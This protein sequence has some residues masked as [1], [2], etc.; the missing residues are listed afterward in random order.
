M[1]R[2]KLIQ[3]RE[4]VAHEHGALFDVLAARRGRISG[5]SSVVLHSPGLAGPWNDVSEFLHG[6]SIVEPEAAELAV[7]V[8]ARHFDCAYVWAAHLPS[9][10]RVGVSE[11]TLTAVAQDGGIDGLPPGEAATVRFV[12]QLL[13]DRRIEQSAFDALLSAHDPR[14]LVE[15]V[16]WIGRYAALSLVIDAFEVTPAADAEV[17]PPITGKTDAAKGAVRPPLPAPRIP[18]LTVREQVAEA[19]RRVFDA[20]AEGRG[21]VRGPF[22]LLL[23]SA[24]LCRIVL[25]LS[26]YFREDNFVPAA[27]RELAIT[28]TAR[29]RDCPYVW[30]AHAPAARREGIDDAVVAAVRDR[31]PVDAASPGEQD[32]VE[33]VRQLLRTHRV[34]QALF[35][36]MMAAHSLPGLVELTAVVGHYVS[37]TTLLNAF[38]VAPAEGAE[39]LP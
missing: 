9:A 1:A 8:T 10:R 34:D 5:P 21:T 24:D 30:A 36:R 6:R 20:V 7:C 32:V 23:H 12:R 11:A 26:N 29:E 35:D 38:E 17:L 37:V 4:D 2:V 19:D 22:S 31:G 13:Q 28:V 14:W 33:Y 25:E 15:L 39:A 18:Q 3:D 27:T 16:S